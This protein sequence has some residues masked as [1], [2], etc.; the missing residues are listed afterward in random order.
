M[1]LAQ[2]DD[3]VETLGSEGAYSISVTADATSGTTAA[4]TGTVLVYR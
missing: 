3:L 4:R 1:A 2:R